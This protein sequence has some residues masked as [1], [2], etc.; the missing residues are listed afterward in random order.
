MT[1]TRRRW[2]RQ[3]T[4]SGTY[5]LNGGTK[6]FS[7]SKLVKS[8]VEKSITGKQSIKDSALKMIEQ[9]VSKGQK[10]EVFNGLT[11]ICNHRCEAGLKDKLSK[12]IKPNNPRYVQAAFEVATH[13]LNTFGPQKVDMMKPMSKSIVIVL[14]STKPVA[15]E[16]ALE[17]LKECVLWIGPAYLTIVGDLG[18]KIQTKTMEDFVK[19]NP[20]PT[21]SLKKAVA[22]SGWRNRGERGCSR[23]LRTSLKERPWAPTN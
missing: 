9:F 7:I 3:S 13:M 23:R 16:A 17:F 10:E 8:L 6:G 1:R 2:K 22:S 5:V 11:G 4:S 15:K 14:N 21:K 18:N 12:P 20:V 19:E